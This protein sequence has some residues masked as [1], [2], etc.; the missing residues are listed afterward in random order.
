MVNNPVDTRYTESGIVSFWIF[1]L[2]I[3]LF[4]CI[5]CVFFFFGLIFFDIML[6]CTV[7][8][9][10]PVAILKQPLWIS[11]STHLISFF[12]TLD[13]FHQL[14]W[15]NLLNEQ[16]RQP[17]LRHWLYNAQCIHNTQHTIILCLYICINT[18]IRFCWYAFYWFPSKRVFRLSAIDIR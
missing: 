7:Y 14:K 17:Q 1:L 6:A 3:R 4:V 5:V 15:L 10:W 18:M 12:L 9:H 2:A 8:S 11:K 13:A 16:K